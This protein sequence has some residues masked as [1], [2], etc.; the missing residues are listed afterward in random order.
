MSSFISQSTSGPLDAS[1]AAARRPSEPRGE[2]V[3]LVEDQE[4]IRLFV[5]ETLE[6]YGYR[7]VEAGDGR[8]A[9]AIYREMADEIDVILTDVAMPHLGGPEFVAILRGER[10]NP[11]VLFMSGYAEAAVRRA[12][13]GSVASFLQ[14]PFTPDRLA[15][16]LRGTLDGLG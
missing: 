13:F 11:R 6:T 9:L 1:K 12:F 7:V 2:T 3:L 14:K 10:R 16:A 5:R 15:T 8:E 4:A